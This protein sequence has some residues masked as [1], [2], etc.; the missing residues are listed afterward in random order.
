MHDS[1]AGVH[2]K[3]G[4]GRGGYIKDIKLDNLTLQNC[5]EG[6][7]IDTDTGGHPSDSPGHQ[8][9]LTALPDIN[10]IIMQ[11]IYG[12]NS[13]VAAKFI[14]SK[15]DPIKGL[16]LQNIYFNKDA[17]FHCGNVTGNYYNVYPLPC[18]NLTPLASYQ[19][20]K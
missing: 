15:E 12:E 3:S 11:N 10:N 1:T 19:A 14:S 6:I 20:A 18:D 17:V 7:M 9:N 2:I 13:T 5:Y 4:P 8:V 16:T